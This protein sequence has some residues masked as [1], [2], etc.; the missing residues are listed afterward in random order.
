MSL[1]I[2]Q[3]QPLLSSLLPECIRENVIASSSYCPMSSIMQ[4]VV[5]QTYNNMFSLIH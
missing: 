3:K 5:K 4:D 2:Q 1:N